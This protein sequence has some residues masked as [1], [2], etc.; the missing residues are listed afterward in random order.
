MGGPGGSSEEEAPVSSSPCSAGCVPFVPLRELVTE[1]RQPSRERATRHDSL[2][3]AFIGWWKTAAPHT[4]QGQRRKVLTDPGYNSIS[5]VKSHFQEPESISWEGTC[6]ACG[7]SRFHPW[8][9][10]RALEPCQE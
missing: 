9:P 8:H 2:P 4:L 3:P 1:H 5:K 6:L 10:R 7:Q